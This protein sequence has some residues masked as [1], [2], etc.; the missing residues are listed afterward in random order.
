MTT[1]RETNFIS[2]VKDENRFAV[3]RVNP[4][5]EID[6][7]IREKC[8][9]EIP[10]FLYYLKNRENKY[11]GQKSWVYFDPEVYETETLLN[12]KKGKKKIKGNEN[13]K[14]N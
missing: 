3:L 7:L 10:Y 5:E 4:I 13:R 8:R 12:I 6:P 11:P 9:T 1:N 2:I 14:N